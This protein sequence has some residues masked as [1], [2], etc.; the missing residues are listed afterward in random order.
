MSGKT[1]IGRLWCRQPPVSGK[2]FQDGSAPP[3]PQRPEEAVRPLTIL[4]LQSGS[5]K[6]L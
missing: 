4:S 2:A 1:P 5:Q 3:I 6:S